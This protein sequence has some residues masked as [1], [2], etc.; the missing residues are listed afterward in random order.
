MTDIKNIL[1]I[2]YPDDG[3][4]VLCYICVIVYVV[5]CNTVFSFS[6][7]LFYFFIFIFIF[8]FIFLVG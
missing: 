8:V 1:E 2:T 4:N 3:V 7:F 5:Y 6:P